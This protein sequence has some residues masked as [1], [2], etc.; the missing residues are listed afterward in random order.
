MGCFL[1]GPSGPIDPDHPLFEGHTSFKLFQDLKT[2]LFELKYMKLWKRC[3][4][5]MNNAYSDFYKILFNFYGK[6]MDE[7]YVATSICRIFWPNLDII[8]IIMW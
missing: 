7:K 5:F 6:L 8:A 3:V 1:L 2:I 4:L